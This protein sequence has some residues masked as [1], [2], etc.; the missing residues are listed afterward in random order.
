MKSLKRRD[1]VNGN[2]GEEAVEVQERTKNLE[3]SL[4]IK[5]SL[6]ELEKE[7]RFLGM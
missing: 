5:M 4:E 6:M 1:T 3:W 7:A 2:E